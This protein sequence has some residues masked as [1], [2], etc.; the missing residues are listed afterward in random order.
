MKEEAKEGLAQAIYRDAHPAGIDPHRLF[1]AAQAAAQSVNPHTQQAI[2]A[3]IYPDR[4]TV[5]HLGQSVGVGIATLMGERTFTR[6]EALLALQ[7]LK[8]QHPDF[9]ARALDA[10]SR[11][12][13]SLE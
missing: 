1:A 9:R 6:T 8:A 11:V 5:T 3:G 2:A 10:V 13:T 7:V 12:F 4:Q